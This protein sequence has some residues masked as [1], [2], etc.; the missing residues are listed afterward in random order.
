MALLKSW[1]TPGRSIGR[2][3]GMNV[4]DRA[5]QML[6]EAMPG[7][8]GPSPMRSLPQYELGGMREDLAMQ[9]APLEEQ[10]AFAARSLQE[11]AGGNVGRA[12]IDLADQA[13]LNQA[14]VRA[15]N[16]AAGKPQGY[17]PSPRM[18]TDDPRGTQQF[19]NQ[20]MRAIQGLLSSLQG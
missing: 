6:G 12:G 13:A 18:G 1:S 2:A 4:E 11:R 9:D 10:L 16:L 7:A 3:G 20:Y 5:T 14:G 8:R 15:G 17:A 19:R